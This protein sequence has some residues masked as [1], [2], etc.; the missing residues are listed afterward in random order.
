MRSPLTP[1]D[2]WEITWVTEVDIGDLMHIV[3]VDDLIGHENDPDCVCGP[4]WEDLGRGDFLVAH[5]ALDKREE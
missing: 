3:P 5:H 2:T 1:P 4:Y